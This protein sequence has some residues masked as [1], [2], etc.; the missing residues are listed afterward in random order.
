MTKQFLMFA[1]SK[2]FSCTSSVGHEGKLVDGPDDLL[3]VVLVVRAS[4]QFLQ[5]VQLGWVNLSSPL[6]FVLALLYHS[7]KLTVAI[8]KLCKRTLETSWPNLQ[9]I[10]GKAD[11][12]E[13]PLHEVQNHLFPF[14]LL[15]LRGHV[16][17]P[18]RLYDTLPQVLKAGASW[19]TSAQV[20][21]SINLSLRLSSAW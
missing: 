21:C 9:G 17:F 16:V 20:D 11:E 7:S 19:R 5:S 14:L 12:V 2:V 10:R 13:I 4:D 6:Q 8:H 1:E 3:H 15:V 18:L